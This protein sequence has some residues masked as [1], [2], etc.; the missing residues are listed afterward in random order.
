ME[1]LSVALLLLTG[2]TH[3]PP[4]FHDTGANK[5]KQPTARDPTSCDQINQRFLDFDFFITGLI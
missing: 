1:P 5:K 2:D 4:Q 3:N